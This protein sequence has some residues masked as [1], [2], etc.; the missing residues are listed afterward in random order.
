MAQS[1]SRTRRTPAAHARSRQGRAQVARPRR[2]HIN[3]ILNIKSWWSR[4][5]CRLPT[6]TP[7]LPFFPLRAQRLQAGEFAN[8][9]EL[10][11]AD[12][13][14][15][16]V[17]GRINIIIP[18]RYNNPPAGTHHNTGKHELMRLLEPWS[19]WTSMKL[20]PPRRFFART[21]NLPPFRCPLFSSSAR[22]C[23]IASMHIASMPATL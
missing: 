11:S 8:A 19:S 20:L 23:C 9:D 22:D 1:P 17:R 15:D 2:P 4:R 21:E 7:P 14:D 12:R 10:V 16:R 5:I 18:G 13:S 6:Q 3:F